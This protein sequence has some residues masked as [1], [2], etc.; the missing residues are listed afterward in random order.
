MLVFY[1]VLV[2][3]VLP[4]VKKGEEEDVATGGKNRKDVSLESDYP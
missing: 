3:T 1:R 4:L 2:G